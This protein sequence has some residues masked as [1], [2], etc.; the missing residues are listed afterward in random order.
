MQVAVVTFDGFNELDSFI[1]AALI[2]RCR[3]EGLEAYITT[4]TPVVTSMNGVQVTGQRPMEFI[5][6]A[7]VVLIGSGVKAREVVADDRLLSRLRLDPSRQLVGAQ[8]SGALVLAGLGLLG[9]MP[10]STDV[11]TRPFVEARGV[12]VLDVPFHS[13]G[14]IATAGGCLA[15]QY[16]ATWVITRTLGEDAARGVLDYVA[17]VGENRETVERALHAVRAGELV[18]R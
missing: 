10:V 3:G 5:E 9:G 16:L 1:A 13:E 15:S 18:Q 2:N 17:P 7:D 14:N 6:D 12:T 11:K 8:C 4:P